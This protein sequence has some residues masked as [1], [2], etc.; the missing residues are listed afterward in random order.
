MK[1]PMMIAA[2]AIA[3]TAGANASFVPG[4]PI[5][6]M[7]A[8]LVGT[9]TDVKAVFIYYNAADTDKMEISM[10]ILMSLFTN[11]TTPQGTTVDLGSLTGAM[12]WELKDMA[13]GSSYLSDTADG[14]GYYHA[15]YSSIYSDFNV[16]LMPTASA[17]A[18]AALPAGGN[19]TFIGWEDHGCQSLPGSGSCPGVDWDYNDLIFAV[20]IESSLHNPGIP[21]PLTLS[22]MGAG[23]LGAF[24]LRRKKKA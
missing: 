17:A 5:S 12:Q 11:K 6:T 1:F 3:M 14:H 9:G 18:L 19:V 21:E 8:S 4:T 7:P 24:G 16:G 22:L 2:A 23:L 13:T 20:W 15:A 10:P